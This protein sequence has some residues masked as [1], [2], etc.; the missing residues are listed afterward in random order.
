[1]FIRSLI[2]SVAVASTVAVSSPAIAGM[3]A[4][5]WHN[6]EARQNFLELK[7]AELEIDI[8][9][10]EGKAEL[11]LALETQRIE[12]AAELGF[13]ITT[14]EGKEAFR[15]YRREQKV[16]RAAELGFDIT[17]VEGRQDFR[18]YRQEQ[19][20]ERREQISALSDEDREALR[21]QLQGLNREERRELLATMF[22]E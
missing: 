13:D 17:T 4:E 2:L 12:A 19:R 5:R 21:E 10:E 14:D 16:D 7:A 6:S 18:E 3:A 22:N 11:K 1:M 20:Q 15:E 8:S 9:T